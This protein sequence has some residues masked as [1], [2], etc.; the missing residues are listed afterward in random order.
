[1]PSVSLG[2][3][4][5]IARTEKAPLL[6]FVRPKVFWQYPF[7]TYALPHIALQAGITK[8]IH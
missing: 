4:S 7:N 2:F 1:M 3:G 5:N 6:F 8:V